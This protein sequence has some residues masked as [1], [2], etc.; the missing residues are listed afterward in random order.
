MSILF[1]IFSQ[2]AGD[3]GQVSL[4][5][6]WRPGRRVIIS[7]HNKRAKPSQNWTKFPS[8]RGWWSERRARVGGRL[9][10]LPCVTVERRVIVH[11]EEWISIK[12]RNVRLCDA[13]SNNHAFPAWEFYVEADVAQNFTAVALGCLRLPP[14]SR[15]GTPRTR[16][17]SNAAAVASLG[18][19]NSSRYF[20]LEHNLDPT[21]VHVA[22][23]HLW[24]ID[25]PTVDLAW[26]QPVNGRSGKATPSLPHGTQWLN[27]AR[28]TRKWM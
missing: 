8:T 27:A 21:G 25:R 18:A 6:H 16:K 10:R 20:V 22:S 5:S 9:M 7:K 3:T 12:G 15:A 17:Y 19:M 11:R 26:M 23:N 28:E 13:S 24:K 2:R 4:K 1:W 14:V